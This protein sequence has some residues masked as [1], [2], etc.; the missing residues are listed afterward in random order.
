[1][2]QKRRVHS[3]NWFYK[4]CKLGWFNNM[5]VY[6]IKEG[7][8]FVEN[9]FQFAGKVVTWN[10]DTKCIDEDSIFHCRYYWDSWM[11]EPGE[12]ID[13]EST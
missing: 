5:E 2:I 6:H 12:V 3:L 8:S 7:L 1:M 9:M 11:F 10:S 13:V 4:H